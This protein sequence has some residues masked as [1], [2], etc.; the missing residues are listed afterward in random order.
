MRD[1][2]VRNRTLLLGS[3]FILLAIVAAIPAARWVDA[4]N[5]AKTPMYVDRQMAV[6]LLYEE[7]LK[8][9]AITAR[10]ITSGETVEIGSQPFQPSPGDTVEVKLEDT[11]YCVQVS[12]ESGH[13]TTWQCWGPNAKP[14][15]PNDTN[16]DY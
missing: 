6:W 4:R 10:T 9:N 13:H 3:L 8:G 7:R 1:A 5:D 2:I 14:P 12:D 15:M 16:I 11:K